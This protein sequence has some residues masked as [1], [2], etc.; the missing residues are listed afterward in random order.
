MGNFKVIK[1]HFNVQNMYYLCM[2]AK[3]LLRLQNRL[4][5]LWLSSVVK[6]TKRKIKNFRLICHYASI[7]QCC[8]TFLSLEVRCATKPSTFPLWV[9]G[10]HLYS[11]QSAFREVATYVPPTYLHTILKGILC[12]MS[13]CIVH[14]MYLP[15]LMGYEYFSLHFLMRA[16]CGFERN[17][18]QI[19]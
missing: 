18:K 13:L 12:V 11:A 2:C 4:D 7:R 5:M 16:I 14:I 1:Y 10:A 8:Q 15:N 3:Q 9:G 6:L 19:C 17:K